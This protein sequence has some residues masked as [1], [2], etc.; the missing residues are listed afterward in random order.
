[1]NYV[2]VISSVTDLILVEVQFDITG[3]VKVPGVSYEGWVGGSGFNDEGNVLTSLAC[4][5]SS[6]DQHGVVNVHR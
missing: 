2:V 4:K 1:L 5:L 3:R 6:W